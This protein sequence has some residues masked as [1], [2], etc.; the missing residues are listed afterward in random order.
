ME[1]VEKSVKELIPYANNPRKNNASVDAVA[2]S[3]RSFGFKVP[4]VIDKD[5]IIVAGHT[6]L[7]AAKKL[8]LKTVPCIIADDLTPEQIQAFRLADNKVGESSEWDFDLLN[9][10][11]ESLPEFDFSEFGFESGERKRAKAE[12]FTEED[13]DLPRLQHN[14]FDNFERDFYPDYVGQFEFP[15]MERTDTTGDQFARFCDWKETDDPANTIAH[16]YYD[17]YKFINIWKDPDCY[18]DRLYEYKAVIS[19]DFSLYTDFPLT[20]QIMSCYRRQWIGAYWQSL[21]LDVIPD[22]IW[23]EPKT[24]EWC[25]DGIP[26]GGTV[27]VSSVGVKRDPDWNGE[28]G[29]FVLGYKEMLK[30]L[31][32][33]TILFYGDLID[34]L[35][36]N[37]IHIPSYYGEKREKLNGRKDRG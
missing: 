10:E 22:V 17:D 30:R 27:A 26:Q 28:D 19:P 2:A 3:I 5:N 8:G 25:F 16:F 1:I 7:K 21:G 18:L 15:M 6:R 13:D 20:L 37:I 11:I 33:D 12:N 29:L 36:G 23:G 4:V 14:C 34:G 31:K 24:F 32:P 9:M 35:D